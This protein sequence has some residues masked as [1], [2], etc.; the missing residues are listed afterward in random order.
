MAACHRHG[1]QDRF[2]SGIARPFE[3]ICHLDHDVFGGSPAPAVVAA[4]AGVA[5]GEFRDL[6]SGLKFAHPF[7]ER[8]HGT[9]HGSM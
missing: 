8:I 6:A 5:D 3:A 2:I 7:G 9:G 1:E 4:D